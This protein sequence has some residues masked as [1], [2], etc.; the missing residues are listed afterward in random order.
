MKSPPKQ[1]VDDDAHA[2]VEA[3]IER[4][5]RKAPARRRAGRASRTAAS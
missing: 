2:L 4:Y 5:G 1:I 3:F